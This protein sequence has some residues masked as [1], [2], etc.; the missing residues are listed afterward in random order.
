MT[1]SPDR[2]DI[3]IVRL[4]PEHAEA[5][6]ELETLCFSAPWSA[7]DIAAL[8]SDGRAVCFV[9][10]CDDRP[11]GYISMYAVLDEGMINNIA[12][13]PEYR[14]RKTA[15]KLLHSLTGYCEEHGVRELTLEV[16]RSNAAAVSLYEKEGFLPVGERKNY[17]VSPREDA[18]LYKKEIKCSTLQ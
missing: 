13:S 11:V 14:R 15:T 5:L 18:L 6:H 12:V 1:V 16:R 17:Y 2:S 9:A 8:A 3:S 7:E 10:L 4:Q